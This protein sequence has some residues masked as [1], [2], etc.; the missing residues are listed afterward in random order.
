MY[1]LL[2]NISFNTQHAMRSNDKDLSPKAARSSD[3]DAVL[4]LRELER[5]PVPVAIMVRKV[6]IRGLKRWDK[7]RC[8][9]G[10]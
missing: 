10:S 5:T 3:K 8:A 9:K 7:A 1:A 2:L 4:Q 6:R